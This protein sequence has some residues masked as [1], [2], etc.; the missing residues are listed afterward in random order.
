[1]VQNHIIGL[2][3]KCH[4]INDAKRDFHAIHYDFILKVKEGVELDYT[5]A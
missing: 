4:I 2:K 5:P 3:N 1:M